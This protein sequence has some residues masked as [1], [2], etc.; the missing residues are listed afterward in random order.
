MPPTTTVKKDDKA[1][2]GKSAMLIKL[3]QREELNKSLSE[4]NR[5]L[6]LRIATSSDRLDLSD[7]YHS[8]GLRDEDELHRNFNRTIVCVPIPLTDKG[9]PAN[10]VGGTFP[11]DVLCIDIQTGLKVPLYQGQLDH[12]TFVSDCLYLAGRK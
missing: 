6:S 4:S 12:L 10:R 9:E 11:D 5:H 8:F 3:E 1:D 2:E 7:L